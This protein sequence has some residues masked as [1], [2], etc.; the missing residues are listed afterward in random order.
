MDILLRIRH[1]SGSQFLAGLKGLPVGVGMRIALEAYTSD[2]GKVEHARVDSRLARS[3][4]VCRAG[5]IN[6]SRSKRLFDILFAITLILVLLP[7][8]ATVALAITIESRGP[9]LFRQARYGRGKHVFYIYKFR[10]MRVCESAGP[11]TQACRGDRRLTRVGAV[12]RHTSVDELPQLLNVV[13][14]EMALVGPRPHA[15]T[16]DDAFERSVPNFSDRHLVRPGL[17]GLAQVE[18]YRGP[19]QTEHAIAGRLHYDRQ[20]IQNWSLWLD[21]KILARTP[22]ALIHANAL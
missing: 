15:V 12:L 16:M 22:F 11:F 19:T 6:V 1:V 10:T 20:Y 7:V 14:G 17:T 13:R 21:L 9:I 3:S 18:G 4:I 8:L 5:R 2:G